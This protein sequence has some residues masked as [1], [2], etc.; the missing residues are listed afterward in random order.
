M[1]TENLISLAE[2]GRES[3]LRPDEVTHLINP[4]RI[5]TVEVGGRKFIDK[6]KFPPSNYKK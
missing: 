5:E 2:F 1:N 3:G 4:L 6:T